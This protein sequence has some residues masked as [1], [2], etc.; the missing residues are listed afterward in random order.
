[1][2][3]IDKEETCHNSS[4]L[5]SIHKGLLIIVYLLTFLA[6]IIKKKTGK[7]LSTFVQDYRYD[8]IEKRLKY[9]RLSMKQKFRNGETK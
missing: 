7:S 9:S 3:R 1:M 4:L 2:E 6:I 8:L 5:N